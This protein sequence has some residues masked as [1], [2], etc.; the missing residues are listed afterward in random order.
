MNSPYACCQDNINAARGPEFE[1]C[2]C[3]FSPYGINSIHSMSLLLQHIEFSFTKVVVRTTRRQRMAIIMQVAVVN[4]K[5]SNVAQIKLLQ[6]EVLFF[7][8]NLQNYNEMQLKLLFFDM[9]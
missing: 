1:G 4:M 3:E 9:S 8:F 7:E 5:S 2:S 6:Q